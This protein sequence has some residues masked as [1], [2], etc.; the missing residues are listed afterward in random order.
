MTKRKSDFLNRLTFLFIFIPFS[1]IAS[2]QGE[3][4]YRDPNYSKNFADFRDLS[5][6]AIPLGSQVGVEGNMMLNEQFTKGMLKLSNGK[7]YN[8]LEMN[9]SWSIINCTSGKIAWYYR[10]LPR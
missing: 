10:L 4:G 8:G 5:G 6:K 7:V 9:L 3:D 1:H 2:G